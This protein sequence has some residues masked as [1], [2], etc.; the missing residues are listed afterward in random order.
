VK[1]ELALPNAQNF[2]APTLSRLRSSLG[3][4]YVLLGSY[5]AVGEGRE[6]QVRLDL[7]LQDT[8]AGELIAAVSETRPVSRLLELVTRTGALMRQKL[9]AGETLAADAGSLRGS[10]PEEPEAA[11]Y[12]SEGLERL[13]RFETMEARDLLRKAVQAAPQHALSHS[14][15]ASASALL[16][17]EPEARAE[18]KKALDLS[19][20]LSR[21]ERLF[22]EGRYY[23]SV[24]GWDRAVE[25]FRTLHNY[26]PDNLEYGLRLAAAQAQSGEGRRA[27]ETL[28]VLRALPGAGRDPRID[29]AEAE[30]ALAVSD[31]ARAQEAAA[32]AAASSM[33]QGLRTLA[34]RVHL[35]ESRIFLEMGEPQRAMAA[36][37]QARDLYEAAGHRQGAA[38][39]TND[40]AAV[41]T[42]L[43]DVAAA[44]ASYEKALGICRAIGDQVCIGTD[45][46]SL[47]V[48]LRR[49]GDLKGALRMH[50]QALEVRRAVGDRGGVATALYNIGNV[51]DSMGDLPGARQ[52]ETEAMDIRRS[53]GQKRTGALTMSRLADVRRRQGELLEAL[54]MSRDAVTELR[55]IGDRGGTAMGLHNLALV[56]FDRGDLAGSRA[57]G[58]EA[59]AV[60]RSQRDKNNTAQ[61]L[62]G[63]GEVAMA[64]DRLPDARRLLEE[65]MALRQGLG[66]KI[67]LA[68]TKVALARLSLEEGNVAPAE[69]L[70]REAAV[71]FGRAGA[72]GAQAEA[73]IV[74]ARALVARRNTRESRQYLDSARAL[75]RES[76]ECRLLVEVELGG[77]TLER[78]QGRAREAGRLADR[79]LSDASRCSLP[80][81]ELESRLALAH[82]GRAPFGPVAADAAQAGYKLVARKAGAG[83]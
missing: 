47:G 8:R 49:Q 61:A 69:K 82:A 63:L 29:L 64:E 66:E 71:E 15:L 11:R 50:E 51:R 65:S 43:G 26:F 10:L 55:A 12:Y 75:L 30:A 23:E 32:R 1:L 78:A 54:A 68:Q 42:Q 5:L 83:R 77:A 18:A 22:I 60:R 73:E 80:G 16:G 48:L 33:A 20:D 17:Y 46:D 57:A 40:M 24:R 21:E 14:A 62:W 53:L 37:G 6:M 79:A 70:A 76:K 44:R 45:L 56:L 13:R 2:A 81:L 74:L 59:L 41:L 34:A 19:T 72:S 58:E 28:Q 36:S 9:G 52:A 4:D 7:R 3:A 25:I 38:W 67:A 35:L 31:L 39:A 27:L